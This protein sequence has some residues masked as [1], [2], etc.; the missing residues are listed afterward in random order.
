LH[1]NLDGDKPYIWNCSFGWHLQPFSGFLYL[2]YLYVQ[3]MD[4]SIIQQGGNS[5]HIIISYTYIDGT[6]YK[7][8]I[9]FSQH[10]NISCHYPLYTMSPSTRS[11]IYIFNRF[12][13]VNIIFLWVV[14]HKIFVVEKNVGSTI[15]NSS[16]STKLSCFQV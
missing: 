16:L 11:Y 8:W 12:S 9:D 7:S 3:I 2:S 14:R 10:A 15:Y 5:N 4:Q 6:H 1:T 13:V